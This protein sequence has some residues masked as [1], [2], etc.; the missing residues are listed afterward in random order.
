MRRV[1]GN[2]KRSFGRLAF[3]SAGPHAAS[4]IPY[5]FDN[6]ASGLVSLAVIVD[7]GGH[8]QSVQVVRDIPGLTAAATSAVKT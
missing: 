4:D 1:R 5:P 8:V 7:P 6:I 2:T 3:Y